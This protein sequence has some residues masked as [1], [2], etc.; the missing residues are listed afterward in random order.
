MRA[1]A[2]SNEEFRAASR[3]LALVVLGVDDEDSRLADHDVVDI[4][5]GCR[6]L[7]IVQHRQAFATQSIEAGAHRF[8]TFGADPPRAG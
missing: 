7:A 8:L 6:H 2:T 5:R 3:N 1:I 4:C